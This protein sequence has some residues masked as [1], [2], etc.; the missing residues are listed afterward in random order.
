MEMESAQNKWLMFEFSKLY[1]RI[2]ASIASAK[3]PPQ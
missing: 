2:C 1:L 3:N